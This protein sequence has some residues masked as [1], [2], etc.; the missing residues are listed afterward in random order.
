[1]FVP[2]ETLDWLRQKP[3]NKRKYMT[4]SHYGGVRSWLL[5][6]ARCKGFLA[7]DLP[8]ASLTI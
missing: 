6:T 8:N 4:G 7:Y 2:P 5:N 3:R 1:M